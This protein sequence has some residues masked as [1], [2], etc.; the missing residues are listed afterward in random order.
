MF[1]VSSCIH[2]LEL[3]LFVWVE[4][5]RKTLDLVCLNPGCDFVDYH[6]CYMTH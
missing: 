6:D 4:M 5:E 1:D 2:M 3:V